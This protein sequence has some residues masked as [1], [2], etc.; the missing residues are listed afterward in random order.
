[1]I[2]IGIDPGTATTGFG[3]I[4][5]NG[6][7]DYNCL[8]YGVIETDSKWSAQA[9]LKKI[10][11]DFNDLLKK[12]NPGVLAIESLFFFKN[13]KTVIPVSQARGV[14]L[15]AAAEKNIQV[16]EFTPLQAKMATVGHGR[17]EK[18]QVQEM[19]KIILNLKEIPKPDD[20]SDALAVAVCYIHSNY[21]KKYVKK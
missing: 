20:A 4:K 5:I 17:A 9:R 21:N 3:V 1:M 14:I 12:H 16:H 10:S 15:M 18:K 2:V 6:K 11:V 7:N 8:D 13:S 19:M